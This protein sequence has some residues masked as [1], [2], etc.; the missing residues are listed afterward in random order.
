MHD[1]SAKQNKMK[2]TSAV[3]MFRPGKSPSSSKFGCLTRAATDMQKDDQSRH[4]NHKLLE[5][6]E[7]MTAGVENA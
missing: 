3:S 7:L 4:N 2:G 6:V 5:N 1:N